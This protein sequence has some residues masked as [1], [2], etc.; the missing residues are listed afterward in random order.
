[1]TNHARRPQLTSAHADIVLLSR[2]HGRR[3]MVFL[4]WLLL[5]LVPLAA[6][7]VE[8]ELRYDLYVLF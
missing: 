6:P 4:Y 8:K 7:P 1:M 2:T 3:W 5:K